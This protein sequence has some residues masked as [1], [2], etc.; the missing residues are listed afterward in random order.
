MKWFGIG[1]GVLVAAGVLY[2]AIS[3]L[4]NVV[5][6]DDAIPSGFEALSPEEQEEMNRLMEEANQEEAE[7]VEEEMPVMVSQSEPV[8]VMGTFGHLA[9]GT[10][11]II[12]SEEGTIIRFENFETING[13]GLNLYLS[14][15]LEAS[16]YIDLGPIRGSRGNIN[17]V[18]PEGIDIREYPY[19]LH[20]CVPFGILFNYA[21][22]T[23]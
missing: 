18:V 17:Y 16:E 8:P 7:M 3:P 1:I 19:I 22:I 10:V 14:K 20:W 6:V 4:F 23:I 12:E 9:S 5:E 2:Y 13:P 15:D 21:N 11:R